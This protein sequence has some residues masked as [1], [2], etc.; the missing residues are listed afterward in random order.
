MILQSH[1]Y[2]KIKSHHEEK[3]KQTYRGAGKF[4]IIV[5][6]S[7]IVSIQTYLVTS[8]RAVDGVKLCK[9]WLPLK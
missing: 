7:I 2:K 5:L 8:N 6:N 3:P 9:K 4:S 1:Y